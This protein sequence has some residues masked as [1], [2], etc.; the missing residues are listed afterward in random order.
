MILFNY[1]SNEDVVINNVILDY[2][3]LITRWKETSL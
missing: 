1:N 3:Q 2:K